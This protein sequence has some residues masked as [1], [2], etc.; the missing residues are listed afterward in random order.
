MKKQKDLNVGGNDPCPCGSGK[1]CKIRHKTRYLQNFV[2][3]RGVTVI[4]VISSH[5]SSL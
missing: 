4:L 3:S 2:L 1:N 5:Q